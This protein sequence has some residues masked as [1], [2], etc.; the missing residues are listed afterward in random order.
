MRGATILILCLILLSPLTPAA[1]EVTEPPGLR[2][3]VSV[4]RL[5]GDTKYE[6][7]ALAEDPSEPGTLVDIRSE[8]TFP[9][10]VTLLGLTVSWAREMAASRRWALAAG[11]HTNVNDPSNKM[12]DEDWVGGRQYSFTESNAELEMLLLT[13]DVYYRIRKGQRT[14][15]SLFFHF[16]Y[17]RIEQHMVG[18]EGWRGSLFSDQRFPVS[19]SAPVIDYEVE[20]LSPQLGAAGDYRFT[21]SYRLAFQVSAGVVYASDTDDH[22]LR[23]RISEGNGWGLGLNSSVALDLLPGFVPWGWLSAS[24]TGELRFF[25]AEGN[26]DQRWYRDEDLPAGTEILDIPYQLE[27]LQAQIGVSVGI[28]F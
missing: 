24:L 26:V 14:D 15:L 13:A 28:S 21:D 20:Y 7:N 4:S 25:H 3:G 16:D 19:G 8:L 9:L 22:L 27:S 11:I 10:D 6:L 1:S 2:V 5:F 23:G 18:F 17:Q 12:T